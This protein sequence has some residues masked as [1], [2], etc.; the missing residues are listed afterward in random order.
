M[1]SIIKVDN[2]QDQAGNNIINE[3]SN[4]ITIGASGDTVNIV[5]TLQNNGGA[6]PGDITSVVA[7]TGLSG[8][9]TSGAATLNI[10][11]AQ[12]TITSLGTITSFRSTGIDDNANALAMTIA[13]GKN[14]SIG[15]TQDQAK[16]QVTTASS[17]VTVNG[18]ADELFIEGSTN[19]GMTIGSGSSNV[20][21]IFFGD[22]EDNDI[23]KLS[24]THNENAMIFTVNAAEKMRISSNG[25]I[26]I[27]TTN[28]TQARVYIDHTGDVND[29]GLYVYSN[30]GQTVPLLRVLQDGAG[31][32]QPAVHV[33][34]DGSA[35]GILIEK[36]TSGATANTGHNQVIADGS[37]NS[38][39]SILS[40]NTS[41]GAV[42]FGDDGNNCI[43]YVNYAHNGN[44]LDFGVNGSERMRITSA[45][46]VGIGETA[47]ENKLHVTKNALSGASYRA[48]APLIIENN[49]DTEVQIL[50]GNSGSG[51]L[52]FGDGGGNFRGA[53][54]YNH[55]DDSFTMATNAANQVV[56]HSNGV[57]SA[58]DGIA[59][60]VGLLNTAS[61][62]LDD[63]EEGTWTPVVNTA[64]GFSTGATNYSGSTAPRYTKIGERVFLQAQVQMGNSSGNVALDDSITMTGLPFTPAD[65]E[66]NTVT[67]YRFNSNVAYMTS[68]LQANGSV[69]SIVRFIKG[70][71]QRNGGAINININYKV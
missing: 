9:A 60:G 32:N 22:S 62:V 13:S 23:G 38:G 64:S 71:S 35:G 31:S 42:C 47:P 34:N 53:I 51:Q 48:N 37:A 16:L 40:G 56:V 8:G 17:G 58:S 45:G 55:S 11:A 20:G 5:G 1:T 63:Y 65:T 49:S 57:I 33:R 59:L 10:E 43:G 12:P 44:H 7:G 36:G 6:L 66:R 27:G 52:R 61:N 70:T 18:L 50:S 21:Q 46:N 68:I 29:N 15:T 30:I 69:L 19:S 41:N 14:V 4:T 67:E 3:N 24:Y 28:S 39:F 2:I 54:S 26:G 25:N